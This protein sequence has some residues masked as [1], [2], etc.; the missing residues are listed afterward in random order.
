MCMIQCVSMNVCVCVCVCVCARA[1]IREYP[2]VSTLLLA[3][4][5][6]R[7]VCTLAFFACFCITGSLRPPHHLHFLIKEYLWIFQILFYKDAGILFLL[8][9]LLR[10]AYVFIQ[11]ILTASVFRRA[12]IL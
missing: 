10:V 3:F 12:L 9:S 6:E 7:F 2:C 5:N 8:L 4:F 1:G 11:F